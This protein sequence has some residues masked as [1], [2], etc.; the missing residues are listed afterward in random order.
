MMLMGDNRPSQRP[1]KKSK[2]MKQ[3]KKHRKKKRA[4]A[5]AAAAL[6]AVRRSE[7]NSDTLGEDDSEDH[8]DGVK[9]K[10][11]HSVVPDW[12]Q[13][14]NATGRHTLRA[15][16]DGPDTQI[17]ASTEQTCVFWPADLKIKEH[18]ATDAAIGSP[19]HD[20]VPAAVADAPAVPAKSLDSNSDHFEPRKGKAEHGRWTEDEDDRLRS[21]VAKFNARNWK[22]IA[23]L[24]PGRD[25]TQCSQRWK[26]VLDPNVTKGQWSRE[27]DELLLSIVGQKQFKNWG[28]VAKSIP[29]RSA[30]QCRERYNGHLDPSLTKGN[31][32]KREDERLME[33]VQEVGCRWSAIARKMPGRT[34][35]QVKARIKT[36]QR[37]QE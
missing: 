14:K 36:L 6:L 9:R 26:K 18:R 2:M 22:E 29:G 31:W 11:D 28:H 34:D 25:F 17:L 1:P 30:K 13:R 37:E 3:E 8:D 15:G 20:P 35:N 4:A 24:V 21:A 10:I 19:P 7:N 12:I 32:T 16:G 23:K 27:E 33:M 5:A